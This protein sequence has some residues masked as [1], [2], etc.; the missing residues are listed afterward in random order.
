MRETLADLCR[1]PVDA[2]LDELREPDGSGPHEVL[3]RMLLRVARRA[4][5]GC[6]FDELPAGLADDVAL[7]LQN[8]PAAD[9]WERL[10]V[11]ILNC[12]DTR[13]SLLG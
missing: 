8:D 7:A 6:V 11:V 3:Q 2:A 4:R 12:Q 10:A 13:E 5:A 1:P 9:A